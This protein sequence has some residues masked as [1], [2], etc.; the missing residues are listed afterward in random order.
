MKI[1]NKLVVTLL[2][3]ALLLISTFGGIVINAGT[4]EESLEVEKK[5]WDGANWVEEIDV[6]INEEISFKITITYNNVTQPQYQ[7]YAENIFV[8]DTLPEDLEYVTGSASP[9]EPLVSGDVLIWDLGGTILMD[10]ESY[11]ITF[12]ASVEDYGIHVNEAEA[13]ADEHCTSLNIYGTDDATV[14]VVDPGSIDVEKKVKDENENWV[15]QTQVY[16]G[17]IVTFRL[18][19][20]NTG[21]STL[22]NLFVND[23]LPDDFV[24]ET[25]SATVDGVPMEPTES[26]NI[27][28]W[29]FAGDFLEE[30]EIIIIFDA[31]AIGEPCSLLTNWVDVIAE[32]PCG[33][34]SVEDSDSAKVRINGMCLE[35]LVKDPETGEWVDEIFAGI[36]D[37]VRFKITICYYG[38]YVL[39]NIKVRDELPECLEYADNAVPEEP[40]IS[41]DEMTLWWNLSSSYNLQNGEC[42]S[43]EFDA[44]AV[45]SECE[46]LINL[47]NVTAD[48]C[49]GDILYGEDI[50]T[51]FV[52]CP[53][54]V[55]A[56]GPY[57]PNVN[58]EIEIE[59][60]A[61]GGDPPYEYFWDLDDDGI[62]DDAT[63]RIITNSWDQ[64]GIYTIW[65]KVIDDD[66]TEVTDYALVR[67][68]IISNPPDEPMI[69]GPTMGRPGIE[70]SYEIVAF[71]PDDDQ[72]FYWVEWGDGDYMSWIGPFDSGDPQ[73]ISHIWN[74][75]GK[76]VI[77]VKAK[78][79][80][81]YDSDW[82]SLHVTM[83][84]N[85]AFL[86]NIMDFLENHPL[87]YKIISNIFG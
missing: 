59:A 15:E 69:T 11:E 73:T 8:N 24:Y 60:L 87:L 13:E 44:M 12:N 79:I 51:V 70:Y 9:E 26:G 4:E 83:P 57:N 35:K 68:G 34:G 53:L 41:S 22:T 21:G 81:D 55:D 36:G 2:I 16:S 17:E 49:S 75:K 85:R 82:T 25:G 7:H 74:H 78:D 18:I 71:D 1:Q 48:E 77:K 66:A 20:E 37:T 46:E 28:T 58:E 31:T 10:G 38:G 30:E 47:V 62:Y 32:G 40:E 23:T 45:C 56:G 84:R 19:V 33:S 5:V 86:S 67:V 76:F 14:N 27:L 39:Y 29:Y 80:Y 54:S 65:V 61:S 43:I 63:G 72:V 3:S 6:N 64:M 42:V 50:A 52:E